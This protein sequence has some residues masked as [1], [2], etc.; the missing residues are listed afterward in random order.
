MEG[1]RIVAPLIRTKANEP[2]TS[3]SFWSR[4][5]ILI[6]ARRKK[7]LALVILLIVARIFI[8]IFRTRH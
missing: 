3:G 8:A 4:L 7:Y 6:H 1:W 5:Y 2:A